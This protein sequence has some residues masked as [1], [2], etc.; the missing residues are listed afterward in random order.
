MNPFVCRY[1]ET[2]E[3][4]NFLGEDVEDVLTSGRP[5]TPVSSFILPSS[6]GKSNQV[7]LIFGGVVGVC[8][9]GGGGGGGGYPWDL[10]GFY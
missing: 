3:R 5:H 4:I 10:M 7:T 6:S 1:L 2:F 9:W 8:V